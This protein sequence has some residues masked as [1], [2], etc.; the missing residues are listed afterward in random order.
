MTTTV[1]GKARD[2]NIAI[3]L[4]TNF[5][6]AFSG[7]DYESETGF[8]SEDTAALGHLTG[9]SFPTAASARIVYSPQAPKPARYRKRINKTPTG[10]QIGVMNVFGDGS[11]AS[12]IAEAGAK[13]W[14]ISKPQR[15]PG[16]SNNGK[17]QTY[18]V[19]LDNGLLYLC[20]GVPS[21]Q[22]A[23]YGATLGVQTAF[24]KADFRRAIRGCQRPHPAV[25]QLSTDNGFVT[26]SCASDKVADA[27]I[28]GWS[29]VTPEVT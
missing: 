16:A 11:T 22:I 24:S 29:I 23:T 20:K 28:A 1:R 9:A 2:V 8:S 7:R 5:Y 3:P 27:M 25:V 18:G 6:Y 19:E 4:G 13:G 17:S 21:T 14:K 26:M 12:A 10:T 15:S